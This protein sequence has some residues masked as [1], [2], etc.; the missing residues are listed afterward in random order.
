[1][2]VFRKILRMYKTNDPQVSDTTFAT[3]HS[4][5]YFSPIPAIRDKAF[6]GP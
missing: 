3:R 2:L 5:H 1:M 4:S 6:K